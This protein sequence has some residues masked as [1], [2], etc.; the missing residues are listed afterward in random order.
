MVVDWDRHPSLSP[1]TFLRH[2]GELEGKEG[3]RTGPGLWGW[4]QDQFG[5]EDLASFC[6]TCHFPVDLLPPA[7]QL[8]RPLTVLSQSEP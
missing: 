6:I 3:R 1:L 5:V 2:C 4:G 7:T 8:G